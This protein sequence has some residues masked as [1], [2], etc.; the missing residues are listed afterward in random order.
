[1]NAILIQSP[2]Q[3]CAIATDLVAEANHR[4]ANSLTVLVSLVRMQSATVKGSAERYSNAEVRHILDGIAARISTLGQLHRI[5]S[6]AGP[7]GVISL[8]PHLHEVSDVLLAALSSGEQLVKV[9]HTGGDCIVRTK[10]VQPIALILC[11]VFTNAIK[12]AHPS[13]VPLIML[14]DSQA[15]SDG[16]LTLTISDDGVGLPEDYDPVQSGGMGFKVMRS[17][18]ADLGGELQIQSTHL[19]LSLRLSLPGMAMAGAKLA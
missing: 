7:D 10:H 8:K 19:G 6:Y 16:R 9:V 13:G 1:M 4:I 11:E 17:L 5:L 14:V 12:Y 2:S 3:E 15:S 18:A